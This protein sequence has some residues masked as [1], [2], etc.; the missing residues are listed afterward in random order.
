MPLTC[1]DGRDLNVLVMGSLS[2]L[3]L[4]R[5]SRETA[6]A[7]GSTCVRRQ[8]SAPHRG[9]AGDGQLRSG[10]T[11]PDR[12]RDTAGWG[13]FTVAEQHSSDA[14]RSG[15]ATQGLSAPRGTPQDCNLCVRG[16]G[17]RRAG[18][19]ELGLEGAWRDDQSAED[20]DCP[21]PARLRIPRVQDQAREQA[22]APA[23]EQDQSGA[24]EGSLYAYPR[25]KIDQPLQRSGS[26]V[27]ASQGSGEHSRSDTTA[28]SHLPRSA[29]TVPK[30]GPRPKAL[31]P[32]STNGWCGVSGRSGSASAAVE[33]FAQP[34]ALRRVRA[35]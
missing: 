12:A 20:A 14:F 23:D 10:A 7:R 28:Q 27:D 11:L 6:D 35:C 34:Q 16:G 18:G 26:P 17:A 25:E 2:C 4:G 32:S 33:D 31:S 9:D 15:D 30:T 3:R 13:S 24:H 21:H 19:G 1:D 8:S 29:H 22:Y 5:R